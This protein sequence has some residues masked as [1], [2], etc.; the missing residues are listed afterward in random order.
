M[1]APPSSALLCRPALPADRD[2]AFAFL[3]WTWEGEDYLPQVW[4]DWLADPAGLFVAAELRG[5]V[6]GL[7][8]LT[9]LGEGEAWLEGLR[10]D[11]EV[12][13]RGIGSHIHHFLLERWRSSR[14]AVVRLATAST[15]VAVHRLCQRTGFERVANVVDVSARAAPGHHRYSALGPGETEFPFQ[16]WA[17]TQLGRALGGLLELRWRWARLSPERLRALA[18]EGM[19]YAWNGERG[20][21]VATREMSE[22][23]ECLRLHAVA[24]EGPEL[25]PLLHE[26]RCLADA[27]GLPEVRWRA[28][29]GQAWDGLLREAGFERRWPMTL[30]VFEKAR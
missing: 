25:V 7:G 19:A 11:P 5:R 4:D 27:L 18:A 9:E 3:R 15:Q 26:A 23:E 21:I 8:R 22:E 20:G 14:S 24:A 16:R 28:P 13:G 29:A 30:L 2:Q 10:V 6:V 1:N 12:Q 17:E